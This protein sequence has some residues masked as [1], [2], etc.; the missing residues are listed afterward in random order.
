MSPARPRPPEGA[1]SL[2]EG[3]G[4]RPKGAPLSARPDTKNDQESLH[5]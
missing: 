1:N 5:A 3:Q 4:Q 2:P